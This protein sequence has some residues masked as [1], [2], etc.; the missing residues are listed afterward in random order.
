MIGGVERLS[1]D[2]DAEKENGEK[3]IRGRISV[4][5]KAQDDHESEVGTARK[6]TLSIPQLAPTL[7]EVQRKQ[8][9][10]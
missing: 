2:G 7:R 5:G 8:I 4:R 9:S 6:T 1:Q 10:S 3:K